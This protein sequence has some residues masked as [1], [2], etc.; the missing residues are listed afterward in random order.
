MRANFRV[1]GRVRLLA[2][3]QS[4]PRLEKLG[5]DALAATGEELF[6]ATRKRKV[7]LKSL[8]LAQDVVAKKRPLAPAASAAFENCAKVSVITSSAA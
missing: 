2:P 1:S 8:L 4:D 6:A 3:G 7:A 5:V